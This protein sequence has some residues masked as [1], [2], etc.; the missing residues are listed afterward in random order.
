MG[1]N[2]NNNGLQYSSITDSND[3]NVHPLGISHNNADGTRSEGRMAALIKILYSSWASNIIG[4]TLFGY[5]LLIDFNDI[6]VMVLGIMAMVWAVGRGM[7]S[8]Y[9]LWT[10]ARREN[11]E[12]ERDMKDY[13][14]PIKTPE[15]IKSQPK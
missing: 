2:S 6:K 11:W 7:I 4:G 9:R 12:L 13:K 5:W 1:L 3:Y 10:K 14:P 15:K 8:L